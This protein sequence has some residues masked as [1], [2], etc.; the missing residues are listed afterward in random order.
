MPF[1]SPRLYNSGVRYDHNPGTC[2]QCGGKVHTKETWVT[3]AGAVRVRKRGCLSCDYVITTKGP[4]T[5]LPPGIIICCVCGCRAERV[6]HRNRVCRPCR[7]AQQRNY[8]KVW[9]LTHKRPS[10]ATNRPRQPRYPYYKNDEERRK[11]HLVSVKRYMQTEHGKAKSRERA[12]AAYHD[13][14]NRLKVLA[15]NATTNARRRGE[16]KPQPCVDCGKSPSQ[17]HHED[18]SRP[19][20]ITWLCRDCHLVRHGKSPS[21]WS[22]TS[23]SLTEPATS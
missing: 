23:R 11:G 22:E 17:A 8:F 10:R 19:L 1:I 16:L 21:I 6:P 9:R 13:P 20:D 14:K 15:R 7:N 3:H 2:P 18:Y 4:N 5:E 12:K